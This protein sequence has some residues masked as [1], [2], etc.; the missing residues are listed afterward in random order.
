MQLRVS[1]SP[2]VMQEASWPRWDLNLNLR[3]HW[4]PRK[5]KVAEAH[6]GWEP[7]CRTVKTTDLNYRIQA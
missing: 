6:K 1:D 7:L 4:N 2:K 3:N 5:D